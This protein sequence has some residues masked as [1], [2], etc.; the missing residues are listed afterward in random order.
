[1]DN[2]TS[3]VHKLESGSIRVCTYIRQDAFS[4]KRIRFVIQD[5]YQKLIDFNEPIIWIE[6]VDPIKGKTPADVLDEYTE[7]YGEDAFVM[8]RASTLM[9]IKECGFVKDHTEFMNSMI[10]YALEAY[11]YRILFNRRMSR[12]YTISD[13]CIYSN[14]KTEDW[15]KENMGED[16]IIKSVLASSKIS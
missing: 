4:N 3:T 14:I 7:K 8:C 12:S 16:K 2:T 10:G 11:F 9:D 15:I 13:I 1:M 6:S 5:I